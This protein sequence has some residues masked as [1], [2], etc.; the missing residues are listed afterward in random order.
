M[1]EA[2]R[3]FIV[4]DEPLARRRLQRLMRADP[5]I[6]IVG[7][8]E[9]AA[10][11]ASS[12]RE[13]AP[14]LLVLDIRM[15]QLDG[16][17]L[18]SVLAEQGLNPYVI[19]VTA[20]SDRSMDAFGVGAVDYLLKP[21]DEE[22]LGRALARA[23][24]LLAG[25]YGRTADSST[26]S[27]ASL[28]EDPTR[29]LLGERGKVVVLSVRDIEFVQAAERHTKIYAGG[30]CHVCSQSL[31]ELEARLGGS[32]FARIH[33]STII[34]VQYLAEMHPSFHGDYEVV[35]KRGTRLTLSRRYRD[36]LSPFLL[37]RC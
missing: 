10:E 13:L 8:Y 36:R 5:D 29:L 19:F 15:P 1:A 24:K 21:F 11:A 3:T 2:I 20:H 33:R 17:Q 18:V 23:K 14:Q 34:N 7:I 4:D 25:G 37:A 35:L 26:L 31:A 12:A 30:R 27:Q 32:S 16:F 22:R 28:A 6:R 9:S